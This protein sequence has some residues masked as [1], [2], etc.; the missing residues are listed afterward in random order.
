MSTVCLTKGRVVR[1]VV[2]ALEPDVSALL[3]TSFFASRAGND[4]I[5]AARVTDLGTALG[6]Q[7]PGFDPA[8]YS[9][10]LE[11]PV[12]PLVSYSY[13]WGFTYLQRA[14][15]FHLRLLAESVP[16]GF[17]TIDGSSAN[18]QFRAG[19]PVFIDIGSFRR[20][21]AGQ[22]WFGYRQFC[23]Q[24]LVPLLLDAKIGIK[25][26]KMFQGALAPIDIPGLSRLLPSSSW[27]SP[28]ILGH[29][30]LTALMSRR[31]GAS[32]ERGPAS[33]AAVPERRLVALLEQ[34]AAYIGSL[35]P[36]TTSHWLDYDSN[37]SYSAE[38][39]AA[40]RQTVRDTVAAWGAK[41]V[42]DLGC[43]AGAYSEVCFQA[44]A[45]SVVG[46]DSDAD[47]VDAAVRRPGLVDRDFTGLV[48][49]VADPAPAAGWGQ[50]E[51]KPL[52]QRLGRFDG[53]VCLALIHHVV[54]AGNV[55]LDDFVAFLCSLAPRGLV[56]FVPIGDPMAQVLLRARVGG[57]HEYD[58]A[59]FRASL[60][61]R[62][63][64]ES[65]I[66]IPGTGRSLYR[67]HVDA[68]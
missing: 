41:R 14:A 13:E 3:D 53:V 46:L 68:R 25:H 66:G 20:Y 39:L 35:R 49:D 44:G 38:A 33:V 34:F 52:A 6:D 24:F 42:L 48:Y 61:R 30:H 62:A 67:Y 21:Q 2:P 60:L 63:Q 15:E 26:Q 56:E 28:S 1:G 32:A 65:V 55:P 54:I 19:R 47:V 9:L 50:S 59:A 27:F 8:R 4:L 5:E 51:R 43:N 57:V 45:Q 18:V 7:T 29:V 12:L 17:I 22:P 10:W 36:T 64:V 37:N 23:E 16:S 31:V 40:K 58:E 11:H